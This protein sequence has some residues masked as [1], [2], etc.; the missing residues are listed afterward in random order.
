MVVVNINCIILFLGIVLET[1]VIASILRVRYKT[2]DT[3]FVLSLC[4]AD[5]LFNLFALTNAFI[6]M[7]SGGWS[8]GNIGCRI[9][10]ATAIATLA[11]SI[12]SITYITINRFIAIIWKKNITR[13]QALVMIVGGWIVVLAVVG[14]YQ[15]NKDLLESSIALQ[16]SYTYC[17][18]DFTATDPIV[19][20]ALMTC[21]VFLSVPIFYMIYAYSRIIIFYRKMNRSREYVTS[22]VFNHKL[23]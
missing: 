3:L 20:T 1:L 7:L 23:Q 14:L 19:V 11:I 2:V 21:I 13:N 8:V 10:V 22:E 6:N 17:L 9:S 12:L 5:I 16:P 15:S 4:C 18:L